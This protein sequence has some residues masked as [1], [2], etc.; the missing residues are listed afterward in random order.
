MPLLELPHDVMSKHIASFLCIVS[1]L[2]LRRA[3]QTLNDMFLNH[4]SHTPAVWIPMVTSAGLIWATPDLLEAAATSMQ[5]FTLLKMLRIFRP[6]QALPSSASECMHLF[7]VVKRQKDHAI[8]GVAMTSDSSSVEWEIGSWW[9]SMPIA[10][11]TDRSSVVEWS[12]LD[13]VP[14]VETSIDF[15]M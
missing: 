5:A 13:G 14:K 10:W 15:Y 9:F 12:D 7:A 11:R 3:C 1:V 4:I 8:L 6:T 2:Q